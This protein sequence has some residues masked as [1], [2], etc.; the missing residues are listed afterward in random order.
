MDERHFEQAEALEQHMRDDALA[1]AARALSGQGQDD[2]EDCGAVIPAARR[3]ALPGA[4]RCVH[5]QQT[6][7]HKAKLGGYRVNNKRW[8][9]A[10]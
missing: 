9:E 4:I 10:S 2:C 7:E 5:C 3:Q 6:A 1:D 8:G